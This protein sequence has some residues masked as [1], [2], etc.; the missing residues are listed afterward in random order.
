MPDDPL[1]FVLW[2]WDGWR[3]VYDARNVNATCRMIRANTHRQH[4]IVCFTDRPRGIVECEPLP[5][6]ELP[7]R[8]IGQHRMSSN[9]ARPNSYIRLKMFSPWAAAEFPGKIVSIDLDAVVCSNMDPLWTP[10]DFRINLGRAS[11]YNGGMWM[12]R[13]GSR[14]QVWE[15]FSPR[16]LEITQKRGFFGS[17]QAWIAHTIP[18]EKTWSEA[19]GVFHYSQSVRTDRSIPGCKIMFCAGSIKPW[20]NAF[21]A[22]FPK[23]ARIYASYF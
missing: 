10:E 23:L 21:R 4:R 22:K 13:T 2:L 1:T 17:D 8:M 12:L 9:G 6:P 16:S 15:Q 19:D 3:P 7:F 5:L 20:D 18:N 14:L 11:P